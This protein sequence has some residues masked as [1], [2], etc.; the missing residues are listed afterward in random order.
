MSTLGTNLDKINEQLIGITDYIDVYTAD[1]EGKSQDY[2]DS[3]M[4]VLS[5]DITEKLTDIKTKKIVPPVKKQYQQALAVVSLLQPLVSLSV[6]DL[7]SVITAV[8]KIISIIT[9]P[10]QPAIDLIAEVAPKLVTLNNNIQ[11]V[12][13][14][15]PTVNGV[16][17]PPLD[18]DIS[19]SMS[20]ITS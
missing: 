4:E 5:N 7:P 3:K 20:D 16:D 10:Y 9:A 11:T 13:T 18:V 1:F 2:I 17:V 14:Y 12:A 15:Q 8:T 6:T 19:L